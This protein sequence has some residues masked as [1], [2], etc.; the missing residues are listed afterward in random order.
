M[1]YRLCLLGLLFVLS[2][3]VV[4]SAAPA[5]S[6][7]VSGQGSVAVVP[8][9]FHFTLYVEEKGEVVSK[10]NDLVSRKNNQIVTFLLDSGVKK[11]H[12]QSM[13]IQLY[14]WYQTH[15]SINKQSGFVLSRQIQVM[16]EELDSY[17]RLIDGLMRLGAARVENFQYLYSQPQ[18]LYLNSLNA[19]L[20]DAS[21]R[22][23]QIA[24][25]MQVKLGNVLNIEENSHYQPR[26]MQAKRMMLS[27]QGGSLP[28]LLD[29]SASVTVRFEIVDKS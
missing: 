29:A 9:R 16:V 22:A 28:G 1:L 14:P 7:T 25:Q 4:A 18:Q 19:A 10:L 17:D 20:E 12:I 5:R 11:Q 6:I 27:E 8:D 21:A 2:T 13:Q 24:Q 23:S 15:D 3:S 26:P